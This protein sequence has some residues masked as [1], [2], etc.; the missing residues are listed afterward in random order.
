MARK[1]LLVSTELPERGAMSVGFRWQRKCGYIH[2]A[3]LNLH[4]A[5]V[6]CTGAEHPH[7][8][9]LSGTLTETLRCVPF[10]L[11]REIHGPTVE[12]SNH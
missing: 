6:N 1:M 12:K 7:D 9:C 5:L 2:R 4:D 10:L 11:S 3:M 8:R